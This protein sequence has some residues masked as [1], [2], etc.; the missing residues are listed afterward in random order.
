MDNS[1]EQNKKL[2]EFLLLELID[3]I[4]DLNSFKDQ[5]EE[6]YRKIKI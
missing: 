2:I 1:Q 5:I 4:K 3:K 6:L